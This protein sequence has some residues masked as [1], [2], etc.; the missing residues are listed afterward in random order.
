MG[1]GELLSYESMNYRQTNRGGGQGSLVRHSCNNNALRTAL[2]LAAYFSLNHRG[3]AY[4]VKAR[5]ISIL[6]CI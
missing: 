5:D 6:A 2:M 4:R 3:F 1:G